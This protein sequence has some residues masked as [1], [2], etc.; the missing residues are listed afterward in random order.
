MDMPV[1]AAALVCMADGQGLALS[2]QAMPCYDAESPV[3]P[4]G[5]EKEAITQL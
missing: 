3:L 1:P 2:R 4:C 5:W